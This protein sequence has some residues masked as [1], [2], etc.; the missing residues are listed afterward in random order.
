MKKTVSL[1]MLVAL[2][3]SLAIIPVSAAS[4]STTTLPSTGKENV[5]DLDHVEVFNEFGIGSHADHIQEYLY[6]GNVYYVHGDSSTYC[7]TLISTGKAAILD[8]S[9]TR[10]D[11]NGNP[12]ARETPYLCIF[13]YKLDKTY[14]VGGFSL[15]AQQGYVE[16][17]YG[18]VGCPCGF[19]ILVSETG[20]DDSWKVVYSGTELVCS[21][22]YQYLLNEGTEELTAFITA[23]FDA[24][25]AQYI[26]F[27]LTDSRCQHTDAQMATFGVATASSAPIAAPRQRKT[28]TCCFRR[29]HEWPRMPMRNACG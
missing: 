4:S 12:D 6:D 29:R 18:A 26:A 22:K 7:D 16:P 24:V 14:S 5:M 9:A 10:Y 21:D 23:D 17:A 13:Q 15:F 1:I 25:N 27:A 3:L 8:G 28:S 2:V 20:A 11:A 19:D